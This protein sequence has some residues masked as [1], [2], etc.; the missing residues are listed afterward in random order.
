MKHLRSPTL[1]TDHR[2]HTPWTVATKRSATS[3]WYRYFVVVVAVVVDVV[4]VVAAV[5]VVVV[6]A[7]GNTQL[8]S[9]DVD[10]TFSPVVKLATIR[11]CKYVVEILERAHIVSY[12][13]CRTPVETKSKL[14]ADGDHVSDPTLYRCN[15]PNILSAAEYNFWGAT[16]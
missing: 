4:V 2:R 9:I 16:S 6:A 3:W 15:T 10:E 13:P 1:P 14:G 7:N 12:N 8:S 5:V 11:T